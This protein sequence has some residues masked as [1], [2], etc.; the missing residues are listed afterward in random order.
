MLACPLPPSF[1]DTCSLSTSIIIIIIIITIII[2]ARFSHQRF[3]HWSLS[4]SK[5]TQVLGTLHRTL[6]DLNNTV[7]WMFS[8]C[9]PIFISFSPPFQ[10]R[11]LRLI[12]PSPSCSTSFLSSLARTK[13]SYLFALFNFYFVVHLDGNIHCTATSFF[14][15]IRSVT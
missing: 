6:T 3:F 2:L 9:P 14:V 11:Q 4:D 8:I 7:Y 10:V 15:I 12:S 5:S 1:L 13:Y